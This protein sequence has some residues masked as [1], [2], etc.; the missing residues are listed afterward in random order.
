MR[1][2]TIALLRSTPTVGLMTAARALG[3][4]RTKAYELA[5]HEQFPCRVIKIGDT[6]RVPT[7]GLLELLG[8]AA[9]DPA[10]HRLPPG[11]P[12]RPPRPPGQPNGTPYRRPPGPPDQPNGASGLA[13][14]ARRS[15]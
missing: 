4:G 14:T 9:E 8:V 10:A 1:P 6:Y 3:L 5:K 13:A 2:V 7:A 11:A 12:D 15:R